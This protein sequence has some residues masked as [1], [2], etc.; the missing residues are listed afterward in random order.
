MVSVPP[1]LMFR[2]YKASRFAQLRT[3]A[4]SAFIRYF[5]IAQALLSTRVSSAIESGKGPRGSPGSKKVPDILEKDTDALVGVIENDVPKKRTS[6]KKTEELSE[7]S[8]DGTVPKKRTRRKKTEEIVEA[9]ADDNIP[10]K[11]IRRKKTEELVESADEKTPKKRIRRKK[12]EEPAEEPAELSSGGTAPTE[13]RTRQKKDDAPPSDAG[14][15]ADEALTH[16]EIIQLERLGSMLTLGVSKVPGK[17]SGKLFVGR[18]K[19]ET[20]PKESKSP[21]TNKKSSIHSGFLDHPRPEDPYNDIEGYMKWAMGGKYFG[22]RLLGDPKRMNIISEGACDDILDRLKPSLEKLK[23]CDVIDLN[24]GTGVWSSKLHDFLKP[25]THILMEPD[26]KLYQPLLQPLVDVPGSTYKLIPRSGIVWGHLESVMNPEHLPF[27]VAPSRGDPLLEQPNNT[28]LVTANLAYNPKKP[29]RGFSSLTQMV[30][31]QFV[32]AMKT[33]ALFQKYG[34]VRLLVWV[35][36]E[37]KSLV[38]PRNMSYRRKAAVEAGIM[39]SKIEEV[40]SSTEETSFWVRE[41]HVS[42]QG[43]RKVMEKMKTKGIH[44][45]AGRESTAMQ[46]LNSNQPI[47]SL[48]NDWTE[49]DSFMNEYRVLE[50]ADKLGYLDT[51]K[52][53]EAIRARFKVMRW[54]K[55]SRQNFGQNML[56]LTNEYDYLLRARKAL[57]TRT[58]R[59]VESQLKALAAREADW[60]VRV[61]KISDAGKT[62]FRNNCENRAAMSLDPPLLLWDRR[63]YEPLK[64]HKHEF[65]PQKE[66]C[67]LDLQPQSLWP[68]LREKFPDNFDVLEYILSSFYTLMSQSVKSGLMGL[69]PGAYEWI[70]QECKI[71]KDP[72]RGGNPDLDKLSVRSLTDEMLEEIVIA[73]LK[74]P[75]R[76]S[77]FEMLSRMGSSVY[78]PD[79]DPDEGVYLGTGGA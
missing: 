53:G 5:H 57:A 30:L 13:Q 47:V 67:L 27:Q 78:D 21:A 34:L 11:R 4:S 70:D 36:D 32:S 31:Y 1:L 69:V 28:L 64:L 71:M 42:L 12:I 74:W 54:T 43:T 8:K 26:H 68:V 44:T 46:K 61:G 76:P 75:F 3:P 48:F 14:E 2:I 35:N 72:L 65:F 51:M 73:W 16:S 24:P 20:Y 79:Q 66:M 6:R 9:S 15:E 50:R 63:D 59:A 17:K 77:K 23:G 62:D 55:L 33:H 10:K 38:L 49:R 7:E 40:A 19:H 29:Y 52:A 37:E 25:R 22:A 58:G 56:A 39:C 18:E 60:Q 41:E 45:P